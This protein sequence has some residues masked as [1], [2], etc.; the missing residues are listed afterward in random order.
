[1]NSV[2][3]VCIDQRLTSP[4]RML[5]RRTNSMIRLVRSTSVDALIRIDDECLA[6]DT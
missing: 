4:S 3:V 1:M 6:V 2:Q 5:N